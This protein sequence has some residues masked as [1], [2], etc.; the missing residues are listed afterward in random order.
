M[1]KKYRPL[2][3]LLVIGLMLGFVTVFLHR[4]YQEVRMKGDITRFVVEMQEIDKLCQENRQE[5]AVRK[6]HLLQEEMLQVDSPQVRVTILPRLAAIC[7]S[8]GLKQEAR[9]AFE[10]GLSLFQQLKIPTAARVNQMA[11]L[12]R[13]ALLLQETEQARKLLREAESHWEN[14]HD[15]QEKGECGF[16]LALSWIDLGEREKVQ[17]K[18]QILKQLVEASQDPKWKL[19]MEP[20]IEILEQAQHEKVMPRSENGNVGETSPRITP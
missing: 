5:D 2:Y 11:F 13:V 4:E 6:V 18:V 7:F 12:S 14:L 19:D 20:C 3:I 8:L 9:Q 16:Y 15:G 17:E 10:E 1:K